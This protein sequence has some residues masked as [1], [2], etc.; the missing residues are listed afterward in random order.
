M[1]VAYSP[2]ISTGWWF[3]IAVTLMSGNRVP[4]PVWCTGFFL[5][6]LTLVAMVACWRGRVRGKA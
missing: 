4:L 6:T 5:L 3:A 1:A 2:A